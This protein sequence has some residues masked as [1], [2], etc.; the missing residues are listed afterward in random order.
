MFGGRKEAACLC[1]QS[2][3]HATDAVSEGSEIV[4]SDATTG[5]GYFA[6]GESEDKTFVAFGC[7]IN[8]N[9]CLH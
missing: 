8:I 1:R 7:I 4:Q 9:S 3:Q 6:L 5:K 2:I